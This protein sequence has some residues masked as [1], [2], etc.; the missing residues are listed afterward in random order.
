MLRKKWERCATTVHLRWTPGQV[1]EK[2]GAGGES[3]C[4]RSLKTWKL[5]IFKDAKND[6][7][8]K[9]ADNWN[10]SGTSF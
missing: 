3:N 9:N 5:L 7:T 2:N 6:N 1:I 4:D 8:C 10:G